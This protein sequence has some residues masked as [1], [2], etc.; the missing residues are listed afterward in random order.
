MTSEEFSDLAMS[1]PGTV[2][3][4]HFDRTAF[5]VEGRRIFATLHQES[6]SANIFLNL[7]EQELFCK[8]NQDIYAVTN[9]WGLKG[10]TTFEFKKLKRDVVLETLK[11]AYEDAVKKKARDK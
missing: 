8:I 3:C 1:F 10:W 4:P 5:K 6:R 9:K 7:S 11:S 2:S